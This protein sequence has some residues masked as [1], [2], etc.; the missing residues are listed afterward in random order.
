M[1]ARPGLPPFREQALFGAIRGAIREASRSPAVGKA[2]RVLHFSVQRDHLH[3]IVEAQDGSTLARGMQGLG[4][5]VARTVNRLLRARGPVFRERF[6]SHELRTPREVRNALVYVLMN[7]KKHARMHGDE[8]GIDAFSSAPWFDGF[9]E[10]I[11]PPREVERP[12]VA[13]R[14]WLGSAGWRRRALVS[15][16]ELPATA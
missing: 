3:L 14:T 15:L 6:H 11:G 16:D 1:R 10:A 9:R 12:V 4:V 5:R 13:A 7:F 8:L 2:F